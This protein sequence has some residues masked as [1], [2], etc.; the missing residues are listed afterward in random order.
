VGTLDIAR[1]TVVV[2]AGTQDQVEISLNDFERAGGHG[3]TKKWKTSIR[4]LGH[5]G[6]P[7][8]C[9]GEWLA[10]HGYVIQGR[11]IVRHSEGPHSK[12]FQISASTP[13]CCKDD[14]SHYLRRPANVPTV[15]GL[16]LD[17]RQLFACVMAAGGYDHLCR[18][19][20]AA[21]QRV[22]RAAG[23]PVAL[24]GTSAWP[25]H[26]V[27]GHYERLLLRIERALSLQPIRQK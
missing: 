17:T 25:M 26:V 3:A 16:P 22:S 24:L 27:R 4:V 6:A 18:L 19:N 1:T 2:H 5:D 7:G 13:A 11:K 23:V 20:S 15:C 10:L 14:Q 8:K 9:I 21:W 12:F